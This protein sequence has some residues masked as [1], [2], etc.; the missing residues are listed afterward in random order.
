MSDSVDLTLRSGNLQGIEREL[1]LQR[2]QLDHLAGA[3][4][5]RLGGDRGPPWGGG[6]IRP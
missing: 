3:M 4:P 2:L 1:R 5:A 6:A